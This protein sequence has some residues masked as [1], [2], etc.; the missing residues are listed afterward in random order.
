E[1]GLPYPRLG[2]ALAKKNLKRAVDRNAAKR[3][4]R[5]S[6]RRQ[7]DALGGLDLVVLSKRGIEVNDKR[8]LHDG[9]ESLWRDLN[10]KCKSLS[11]AQSAPTAT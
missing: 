6:F 8:G 1:N 9:L 4:I 2:M 10:R 3:V 11:S 5:E 7:R